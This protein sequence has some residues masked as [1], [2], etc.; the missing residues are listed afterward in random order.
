MDR[1][2]LKQKIIDIIC[3]FGDGL[4]EFET[5]DINELLNWIDDLESKLPK[6]GVIGSTSL[7]VM[8]HLKEKNINVVIVDDLPP[9]TFSELPKN[10]KSIEEI[11]KPQPLIYKMVR[12]ES[13]SYIP[14]KKEVETPFYAKFNKKR[15][16]KGRRHK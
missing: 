2:K 6:I 16:K 9:C 10:L 11:S 12:H 15:C 14:T 3:D 5:T 7:E 13:T 1:Q 4:T 8:R